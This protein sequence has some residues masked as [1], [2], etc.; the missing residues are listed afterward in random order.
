[1]LTY[2]IYR[3]INVHK[4]TSNL[5]KL[6]TNFDK[7]FITTKLVFK[8]RF[9]QSDNFIIYPNNP[10]LLDYQVIALSLTGESLGI[11]SGS[12]FWGKLKFDHIDDF[13]RPINRRYFNRRRKRLYPFIE[14]LNQ[15]LVGLL[16]EVEDVYLIDFIPVPVCEIAR[17]KQSKICK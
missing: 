16:N 13:L 8:D 10:K 15:Y 6:K 12:Y 3:G 11:G 5:H 7:F 2:S 1:M 17:E 9:N 4:Y 14:D